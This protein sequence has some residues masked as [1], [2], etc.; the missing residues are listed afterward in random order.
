MKRKK[1]IIICFLAISVLAASYLL[2]K[3]DPQNNQAEE[4]T[5]LKSAN[6]EITP[7]VDCKI[8]KGKNIIY[9]NSFELAWK[10]LCF[11][12]TRGPVVLEKP[13]EYI[14][15]LNHGVSDEINLDPNHYVAQAGFIN[16]GIVAK[17]N[18]ELKTKFGDIA[19]KITSD[20]PPDGIIAFAYLLK[21]IEFKYIF[22][23][24]AEPLQFKFSNGSHSNVAAFGL[25]KFNSKTSFEVNQR[26]AKESQVEV[27]YYDKNNGFILR[28]YPSKI[29]SIITIS[30][31]PPLETLRKTYIQVNSIYTANEEKRHLELG[32]TFQIP[33]I[34]FKINHSYEELL[35]QHILNDFPANSDKCYFISKAMQYINFSLNEKGAKL[36]SMAQIDHDRGLRDPIPPQDFIV[37]GPFIIYMTELFEDQMGNGKPYFMMYVDNDELLV[38]K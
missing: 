7:I 37:N 4:K 2:P 29:K 25:K 12:I 32:D 34:D 15:F 38:K 28:L 33:K 36:E 3:P 6:I 31:L 24:I 11:D 26:Q 27:A 9:C 20:L 1:T 10:R 16:D 13:P 22:D 35:G 18:D 21:N 14:N 5:I 30:T 23:D 8:T 19:P 17:I